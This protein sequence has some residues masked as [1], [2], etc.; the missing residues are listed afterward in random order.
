MLQTHQPKSEKKGTMNI[1]G[2]VKR[3]MI[4]GQARNLKIFPY[5]LT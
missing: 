2:R 4:E 1:F 5:V 3:C